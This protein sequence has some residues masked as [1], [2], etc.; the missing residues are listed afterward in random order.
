MVKNLKKIP[1]SIV[2]SFF[3]YVLTGIYAFYTAQSH[4]DIF[5]SIKIPIFCI[6]SLNALYFFYFEILT[7]IDVTWREEL[8]KA[9]ISEWCIRVVN[10]LILYLMWFF[11][12]QGTVWSLY[13]FAFSLIALYCLFIRWDIIIKNAGCELKLEWKGLPF[14]MIH[15]D[16][17]GLVIVVIITLFCGIIHIIKTFDQTAVNLN[18]EVFEHPTTNFFFGALALLYMLLTML[19]FL[20][21]KDRF[22][23]SFKNEK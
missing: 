7:E 12:Q 5:L 14:K 13:F 3:I 2:A 15:F 23:K 4:I 10:Q 9:S 21:T 19:G 6:V 17:A 18:K 22:I 8:Q 1:A 20:M 11:L 16:I